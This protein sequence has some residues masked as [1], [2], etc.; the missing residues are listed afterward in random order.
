[1]GVIELKDGYLF[2]TGDFS[3]IP[4]EKTYHIMATKIQKWWKIIYYKI[5]IE[6]A[7]K[8]RKKHI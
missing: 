6:K 4:T 5:L 7:H 2:L 3:I 1:M 8:R